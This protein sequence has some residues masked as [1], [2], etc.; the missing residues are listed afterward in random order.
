MQYYNML[1]VKSKEDVT[2]LSSSNIG[3]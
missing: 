2:R 1:N 3:Q